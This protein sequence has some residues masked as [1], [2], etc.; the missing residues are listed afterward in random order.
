MHVKC[1]QREGVGEWNKNVFEW[2]LFKENS[3]KCGTCQSSEIRPQKLHFWNIYEMWFFFSFC[4]T[5]FYFLINVLVIFE[6]G[7]PAGGFI[8]GEK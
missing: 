5:L 1:R 7:R 2:I 4:S 6:I 8:K 3:G